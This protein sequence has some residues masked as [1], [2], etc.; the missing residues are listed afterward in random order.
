MRTSF[1]DSNFTDRPDFAILQSIAAYLSASY[2]QGI[3]IH[4]VIFLHRIIDNR[5]TG[6]ARRNI[7]LMK[8]LCG[9]AYF[10]HVALATTHWSTTMES[11]S[12]LRDREILLQTQDAFFRPLLAGGAKLFRHHDAAASACQIVRHLINISDR[13]GGQ[14]VPLALQRELVDENKTL[15]VTAAGWVVMDAATRKFNEAK[16]EI[17]ALKLAI[18]EADKENAKVLKQMKEENERMVEAI[19]STRENMAIRAREI[20]EREQELMVRPSSTG[21]QVV[22]GAR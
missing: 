13:C 16:E 20:A 9:P 21:L 17:A 14:I 6:S 10:P 2:S 11:A 8:A 3:R 22:H 1:D 12:R 19:E 7:E 15:D 4:G 5:I 18:K